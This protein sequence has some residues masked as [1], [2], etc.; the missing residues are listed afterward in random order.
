MDHANLGWAG[1][2]GCELNIS[3]A[4]LLFSSSPELE[5]E[6]RRERKGDERREGEGRGGLAK[7]AGADIMQRRL[8]SS[9]VVW[10]VL[11]R[12]DS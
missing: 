10:K 2:I 6:A 7:A 5:E 11:I 4:C 3:A 1:V 9:W 8:S 12:V